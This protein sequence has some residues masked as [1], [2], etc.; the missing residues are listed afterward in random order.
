MEPSHYQREYPILK[1]NLKNKYSISPIKYQPN[2]SEVNI[3]LDHHRNHLISKRK[4]FI[5]N[6]RKKQRL[7]S[8]IDS[9]QKIN[10]LKNNIENDNEIITI[11]NIKKITDPVS[12]IICLKQFI[13]SNNSFID[14]N[15]I[16]NNIIF[17]KE[18][19]KDFKKYLF[20]YENKNVLKQIEININII[21]N[22]LSF[23]FEPETNPIIDELDYEF[24]FN[25]NNFCLYYLELTN[26]NNIKDYLILDLYIIFLLNNIIAV[27]PDE[28][29]VKFLINSKNIIQLCYEKFFSFIKNNKNNNT[30]NNNYI[31]N[32]TNM[33]K[34]ELLEFAFFK[35][36]ENCIVFLHLNNTEIEELLWILLSILYYNYYNNNIKLLIYSLECLIAINQSQLLFDNNA[37]NNFLITAIDNMIKKYYQI[38][39][40]YIND[41]I[42][43][44]KNKLFLKLYLQ[45]LL[46]FLNLECKN[47]EKIIQNIDLFFKEDIII[48][49]K[50][51]LYNFYSN[52]INPN[53]TNNNKE[54]EKIELKTLIKIIK[55]FD[56]YFDLL[57]L[58]ENKNKNYSFIYLSIKNKIEKF[59]FSF[60]ILKD[61]K[62]PIALYDIFINIFTYF[63]K[64]NDKNSI[65]ISCLIINIFNN[66]FSNRN[67]S[68]KN[69]QYIFEKQKFLIDNNIHRKI[70]IF[71]NEEK[72]PF[73][74]ENLLKF[75]HNI[76]FFCE[77]YD[78]NENNNN[79]SLY[80]RIR[81]DLF[82]LNVF[83]ETEN[84]EFNSDNIN[85]KI[86]AENINNNYFRIETKI[87]QSS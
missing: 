15:F 80:D 51:Y 45:N 34:F 46:Q 73:I 85:L 69:E 72:Y 27:Y 36:I 10:N 81:K 35:L 32:I 4:E 62:I 63:V 19:F 60:L 84:I 75:I 29:C 49:L 7:L 30:I 25:I 79:N 13:F 20:D 42:I 86:Y 82:D 83:D 37:Y 77:N 67:D 40:I 55:I 28:E 8:I 52:F 78:S 16:N 66:I 24:F 12:R 23:L 65:K 6:Y 48:F 68:S 87:E 33:N 17:I 22:I 57:I 58:D 44:L 43:L 38:P 64:I 11:E 39:Y 1:S 54:I 56:L 50:N 31:N 41:D 5:L 3:I 53:N 47:K 76:L 61:N 71:L 2:E 14:I 74:V 21:Y 26:D 59:L 70:L 9:K 18:C